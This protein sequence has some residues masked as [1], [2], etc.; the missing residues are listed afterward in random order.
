MSDSGPAYDAPPRRGDDRMRP[1]TLVV[2]GLL[3]VIGDFTID[4]FDL[5]PDPVG[6]LVVVLGLAPL[7]DRHRGFLVGYWSAIALVPLSL[8]LFSSADLLDGSAQRAVAVLDALTSLAVEAGVLVA[9]AALTRN[10]GT[11]RIARV[12]LVLDVML[13]VVETLLALLGPQESTDATGGAAVVVVLAVVGVL[14]L[15]IAALIWL[16]RVGQ[17]AEFAR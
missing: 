17:E 1:L 13:T 2:I 14:A 10:E 7:R 16:Y 3:L 5:L 6:W 8:L 11:R 15:V 4:G 9:V 12:A